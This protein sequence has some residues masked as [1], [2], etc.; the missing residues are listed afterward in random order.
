MS[1]GPDQYRILRAFGNGALLERAG[2]GGATAQFL[3]RFCTTDVFFVAQKGNVQAKRTA[4]DGRVLLDIAATPDLAYQ[5]G[6]AL[7]EGFSVNGVTAIELVQFLDVNDSPYQGLHLL[8][9]KLDLPLRAL[10]FARLLLMPSA[11]PGMPTATPAAPPPTNPRPSPVR[12]D[13]SPP[14]PRPQAPAISAPTTPAQPTEPR[15]APQRVG[16]DPRPAPRASS[17]VKEEPLTGHEGTMVWEAAGELVYGLRAIREQLSEGTRGLTD[18]ET[19]DFIDRDFSEADP[20]NIVKGV[21]PTWIFFGAVRETPGATSTPT[22]WA[23]CSRSPW[24][25]GSAGAWPS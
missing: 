22:T 7:G 6:I 3:K 15:A 9:A 5:S 2:K 13:A 19:A 4:T 20:A 14:T 21:R 11:G 24:S 1:I 17:S 8:G 10:D 12:R 23:T 25:S 18:E 16:A